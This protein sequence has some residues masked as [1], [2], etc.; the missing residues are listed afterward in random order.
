MKNENVKERKIDILSL[1]R[2]FIN[3][4]PEEQTREETILKDTKL[5]DSKKKELLKTLNRCDTMMGKMFSGNNY[6]EDL[7]VDAKNLKISKVQSKNIE[8]DTYPEKEQEK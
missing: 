4:V 8:R 2:N 6:Y 7:K 1:W 3:P 5:S